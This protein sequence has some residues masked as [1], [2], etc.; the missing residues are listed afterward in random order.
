[1]KKAFLRRL[2]SA[3]KGIRPESIG[4]IDVSQSGQIYVFYPRLSALIRG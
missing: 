4:P 1:M 2:T 3:Q